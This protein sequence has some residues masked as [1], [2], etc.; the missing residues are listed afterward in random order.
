MTVRLLMATVVFRYNVGT[1][2]NDICVPKN[3]INYS[4]QNVVLSGIVP[5][6]ET[7]SGNR[8]FGY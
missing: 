3:E 1:R 8:C 5:N 2:K 4:S 6:T 7:K